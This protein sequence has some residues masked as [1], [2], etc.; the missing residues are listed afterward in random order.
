MSEYQLAML[1]V[2]Q[3]VFVCQCLCLCVC[4]WVKIKKKREEK[5]VSDLNALFIEL[6]LTESQAI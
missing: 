4:D 1:A 2:F 6:K 3:R 5:R